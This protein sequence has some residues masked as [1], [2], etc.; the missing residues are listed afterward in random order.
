MSGVWAGVAAAAQGAERYLEQNKLI[1]L[2]FAL[3]LAAWLLKSEKIKEGGNRLLLYTIV[4]CIL[5]LCPVT[6]WILMKYQTGFYD[7]EW[8]WSM[9]PQTAVIAYAGTLLLGQIRGK[10][11]R[12]PAAVLMVLVL[13]LC[14][15]QGN[16]Q[17]ISDTEADNRKAAEQILVSL[18]QTGDEDPV[19]VWAPKEIMQQL[20]RMDGKILLVYGRDMWDEKSGAYD[21]ESYSKEIIESYEWLNS[22]LTEA[23]SA[24]LFQDPVT[25]LKTLCKEGGL[26]KD[27]KKNIGTVL[28]AGADTIILPDTVAEYLNDRITEVSAQR[29]KTVYIAYTEGYTILSLK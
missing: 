22:V 20:R 4:L 13:F 16:F 3:L 1:A 26:E 17:K 14:G 19:T 6:A 9:V 18:K 27:A 28:D 8:A 12:I 21:Y 25:A 2:L 10:K 29:N 15:N 5:L 23:E 7:Y 24:V 11:H